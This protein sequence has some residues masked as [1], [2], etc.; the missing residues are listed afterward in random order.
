[1]GNMFESQAVREQTGG[2][3]AMKKDRKYYLGLALFAYSFMPY[4]FTFLVLPFLPISKI[5]AV[6]IA[7]GLLIS[8]EISFLLCVVL[9]GKPFIQLL[10]SKIKGFIFRKKGEFP[11]KP[12]GKFRHHVGITM[13]MVASIVPY[14][15]T[16]IALVLGF[17]EKYGHTQLV[18]LL[19]MGDVLFIT[20]FF[21]LGGEFWARVNE[22]FAWP[23]KTEVPENG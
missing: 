16:E 6:S 2:M 3:H 5:K 21:V 1:M 14:F 13:L 22:L 4:V 9:L 20:S 19:V 10:K 23:G 7:T 11:L 8:S 18:G 17:V 12:V 15:L